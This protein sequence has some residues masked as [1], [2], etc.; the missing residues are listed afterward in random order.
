MTEPPNALRKP[1]AQRPTPRHYQTVGAFL[2]GTMSQKPIDILMHSH[3]FSKPKRDHDKSDLY[4]STTSL[5][6][7]IKHA[8]P[9]FSTWAAEVTIDALVRDTCNLAAKRSG[10]HL[11]ARHNSR[12][13]ED[14]STMPTWERIHQASSG[15][16][17]MEQ[18]LQ[19]TERN[20]LQS[21]IVGG[22]KAGRLVIDNCQTFHQ[23]MEHRIDQENTMVVGTA[24]TLIVLKDFD[25]LLLVPSNWDP[26]A[27]Q[28]HLHTLMAGSLSEEVDWTHLNMHWVQVLVNH[29]PAFGE[30][31][32]WVDLLF[33]TKGAKKPMRLPHKTEIYPLGTSNA[34]EATMSRMKDGLVDFATQLGLGDSK[35]KDRLLIVSR[36]G[37]TFNNIVQLKSYMETSEDNDYHALKWVLPQLETWHTEWTDLGCIFSVHWG[38]ENTAD[39]SSL[40]HNTIAINHP[41]PSKLN[42]PDYYPSKRTLDLIL[43][44]RMLDCWRWVVMGEV[45]FRKLT[46]WGRMELGI[47]RDI[48]KHF[49]NLKTAHKLPP[50]EELLEIG[51][52]L[53]SKYSSASACCAALK[54]PATSKKLRKKQLLGARDFEEKR[55]QLQPQPDGDHTLANSCLFLCDGLLAREASAAVKDADL[56]WLYAVWQY[57]FSEALQNMV[58]QNML[59]NPSGR[60]DGTHQADLMQEHH[61]RVLEDFVQHK[62][63][64]FASPHIRDGIAPNV[65][66][67]QRIKES[68]EQ[69]AGLSH[70]ASCHSN[71]VHDTELK[72]LL[73]I[74]WDE[75]L[76]RHRIGRT[77]GHLVEDQIDKGFQK[78]EEGQLKKYIDT[79]L[80][81]EEL[82]PNLDSN[83]LKGLEEDTINEGAELDSDLDE[84]S[85]NDSDRNEGISLALPQQADEIDNVFTMAEEQEEQ[86]EDILSVSYKSKEVESCCKPVVGVAA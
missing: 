56:G 9:A 58:L 73:D 47:D 76:H 15:C 31:R 36:D 32:E 60:Q 1:E 71:Q 72:R 12:A 23:Q 24:A 46:S 82:F 62:R 41:T 49:A 17:W 42:K 40:W 68:M 34:E 83:R 38:L 6:S 70:R 19:T 33:K 26:K 50:H 14:L 51:K 81:A 30:Y 61:N 48:T 53:A 27:G 67:L 2:C 5:A 44:A 55:A 65:H 37:L 25:P 22:K 80:V 75:Q 18:L 57:E 86:E 78:L 85:D 11:Q 10:L 39:P 28:I 45:L 59:V 21:E 64:E 74:Y 43:D 16:P 29:V 54:S 84:G 69:S 79:E 13:K 35:L 3:P 77:Y 8:C 63:A 20:Q 66:H 52:V 4:F 7:S